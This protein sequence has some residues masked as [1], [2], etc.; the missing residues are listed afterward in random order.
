MLSPWMKVR[1]VGLLWSE[2]YKKS[3]K[4][5]NKQSKITLVWKKTIIL[6]QDY[7]LLPGV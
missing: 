1:N 4:N 2:F 3:S 6:L 5:I 7:I